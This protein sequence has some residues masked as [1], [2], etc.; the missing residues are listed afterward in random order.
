MDGDFEE[1]AMFEDYVGE[2][3][4]NIWFVK[5]MLDE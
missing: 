4:K 3:S 1:V 5:V 2:Y